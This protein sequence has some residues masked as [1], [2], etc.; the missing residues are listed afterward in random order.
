MR[1]RAIKI[2]NSLGDDVRVTVKAE[3]TVIDEEVGYLTERDFGNEYWNKNAEAE[4]II[5]IDEAEEGED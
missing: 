4:L 3:I 2:R 1:V 5:E